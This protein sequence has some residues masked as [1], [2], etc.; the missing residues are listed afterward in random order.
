MKNFVIYK[1]KYNLLWDDDKSKFRILQG[2]L[3]Y[4]LEGVKVVI[5][6]ANARYAAEYI[7]YV[8]DFKYVDEFRFEKA[9]KQDMKGIWNHVSKNNLEIEIFFKHMSELYTENAIEYVYRPLF[10]KK[11]RSQSITSEFLVDKKNKQYKE[12]QL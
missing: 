9:T 6:F 2:R 1:A 12:D 11:F 7:P 4:I 8:G 3:F 10:I 5:V